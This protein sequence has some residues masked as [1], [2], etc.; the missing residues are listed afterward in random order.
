MIVKMRSKDFDGKV[1][2]VSLGNNNYVCAKHQARI[3]FMKIREYAL[4]DVFSD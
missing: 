2:K 3:M 1:N 4:V